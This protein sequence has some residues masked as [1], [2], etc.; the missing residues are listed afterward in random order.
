VG[1]SESLD[2]LLEVG[3]FLLLDGNELFEIGDVVLLLVNLLLLA[4]ARG[5]EL[6]DGFDERGQPI[7]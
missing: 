4:V 6:L 3:D 5:F 1:G 7:L 2:L